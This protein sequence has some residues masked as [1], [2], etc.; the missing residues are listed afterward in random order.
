MS[1][2][3]TLYEVTY[4]VKI[5]RTIPTTSKQDLHDHL[6]QQQEIGGWEILQQSDLTLREIPVPVL[7]KNEPCIEVKYDKHG[8][9][10]S[11]ESL[12]YIPKKLMEALGIKVTFEIVT[13][14]DSTHIIAWNKHG[15]LYTSRGENWLDI[16]E[17]MSLQTFV[18]QAW[19]WML[20]DTFT[21]KNGY[22]VL[23]VN[24]E[25]VYANLRTL[26]FSLYVPECE[27]T[28]STWKMYGG[29][30]EKILAEIAHQFAT[31]KNAEQ[32]VGNATP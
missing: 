26:S 21:D 8:D 27:Q 14:I 13:G 9:G 2:D 32:I 5:Q 30:D 31:D 6:T 18:I 15:E 23:I 10:R 16:S 12:A 3:T 29:V 22:H 11:Y 17:E 1:S 28:I 7:A 4:S 20:Y 24:E 25:R 19:T